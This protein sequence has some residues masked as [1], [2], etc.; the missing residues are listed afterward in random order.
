MAAYIKNII[1]KN[2]DIV[3][4][5]TKVKAIFDDNG[6]RLDNILKEKVNVSD[7]YSKE[8]VDALASV[9]TSETFNI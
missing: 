9:D 6:N 3:Y 4:P 8:E 1:D 5:Q 2:G 7:V